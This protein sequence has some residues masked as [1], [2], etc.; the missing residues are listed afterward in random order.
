[1]IIPAS[2]LPVTIPRRYPVHHQENQ[3]HNSKYT[4]DFNPLPGLVYPD[5]CSHMPQSQVQQHPLSVRNCRLFIRLHT[6]QTGSER[7]G[8]RQS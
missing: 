3:Q 4:A 7:S 5:A 1:M 6:P 2:R 8:T